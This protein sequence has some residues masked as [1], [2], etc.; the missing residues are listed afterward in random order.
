[1]TSKIDQMDLKKGMKDV[2]KNVG[3]NLGKIQDI[4]NSDSK[5]DGIVWEKGGN[6]ANNPKS[7]SHEILKTS[8][9][10]ESKNDDNEKSKEVIEIK[11]SAL[12]R[13]TVFSNKLSM[14]IY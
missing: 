10:S 7:E 5:F 1:M 13:T 14:W 6:S 11:F 3:R 4:K 9:P 12:D 2:L 8:T